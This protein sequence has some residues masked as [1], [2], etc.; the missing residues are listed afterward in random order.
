[1]QDVH[2][3]T[4]NISEGGMAISTSVPFKPDL[5]T[6]PQFQLPGLLHQFAP[7]SECCWYDEKGYAGLRFDFFPLQQK[8]DLQ[9]WLSRKL[10][11]SLPEAVAERF[12]QAKES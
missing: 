9:E 12:R 2:C 8:S 6:I 11:E 7:E 10:E 5:R 3:Q 1:M 4:V